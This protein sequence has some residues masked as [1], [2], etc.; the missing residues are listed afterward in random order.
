MPPVDEP[1]GWSTT[2]QDAFRRFYRLHHEVMHEIIVDDRT[3]GT[4]RLTPTADD[5]VAETG[6]WLGSSARGK[7]LGADVLRA[8]LDH[9]TNQV[10]KTVVADTTADNANEGVVHVFVGCGAASFFVGTRWW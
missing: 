8:L 6:M 4:I 3:V 10:W 2:C 7:G 5:G 1:P 9:A